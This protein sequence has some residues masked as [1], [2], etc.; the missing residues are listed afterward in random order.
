MNPAAAL[1][2]AI[3]TLLPQTQCRQCGYAGCRPYAEAVAAGQAQ[4]NQCPP[5][6]DAV[7][8]KLALTLN[9]SALPL[10]TA[11]GPQRRD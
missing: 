9:R 1:A 7:I 5:G 10:K 8:A 4:I 2:D 11:H 3:D 6:G